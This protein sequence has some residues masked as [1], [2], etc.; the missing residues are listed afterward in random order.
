MRE[1]AKLLD[2]PAVADLLGVKRA[3]LATWRWRGDGPPFV[4]V[5]SRVRYSPADLDD[6]LAARRRCSTSDDGS[7]VG[8]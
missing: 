3:T 2:P 5:G 4:R 6:W 1:N 8:A 7:T